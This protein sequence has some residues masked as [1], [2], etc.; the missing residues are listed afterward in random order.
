MNK[1]VLDFVNKLEGYKTA[2]K[3]LHWDAKNMSQ[4]EL[5]DD[6]ADSIAEFQDTVSEVEQSITGKLKVNSLKPTEYKIKDLKSFVQDVLDETNT[7]YKEVK[8]M[9]DT[10]V[11]MA[12]GS[13]STSEYDGHKFILYRYDRG[14]GIVHHPDCKCKERKEK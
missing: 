3:Q 9:G 12:S 8:D 2:I 7:F 1:K 11:G 14:C 5:C 4:H 13:L 6:I 10:Y